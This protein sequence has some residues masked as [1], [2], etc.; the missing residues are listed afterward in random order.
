MI[1]AYP[2]AMALL[3]A[4]YGY[5]L[6]HRHA[7]LSAFLIVSCWMAVIGCRGYLS[8]RRVIAGLDFIA[9]GMVLLGLAVLTS[10]AK[11]GVLPWR[12]GLGASL[13]R[14]ADGP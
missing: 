8:L 14:K 7:I 11:G 12:R 4:G 6:G 13:D 9:T 5:V 1:E 2:L 10:M 3:I